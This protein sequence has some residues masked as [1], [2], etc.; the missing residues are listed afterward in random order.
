MNDIKLELGLVIPKALTSKRAG[1]FF[2]KIK[3]NRQHKIIGMKAK[4]HFL[5]SNN[6]QKL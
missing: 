4:K 3:S 1:L 2:K 6:C 5:K